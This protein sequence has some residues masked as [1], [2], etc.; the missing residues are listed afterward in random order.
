MLFRKVK[1]V[2][3]ESYQVAS[4]GLRSQVC[5]GCGP[6][7]YDWFVPDS[8][9]GVD[10]SECCN[11][12]DWMYNEGTTQK[13]RFMADLVFYVNMRRTITFPKERWKRLRKCQLDLAKFYFLMV[14]KHG[15]DAFT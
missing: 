14:R 11:I 2:S 1:L 6:K 3:P 5:N 7:G 9:L 15:V 4:K 13:H 12:H 10:I 8:L